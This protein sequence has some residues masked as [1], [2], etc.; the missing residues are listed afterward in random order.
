MEPLKDESA[1]ALGAELGLPSA[2][3]GFFL[4]GSLGRAMSD[5]AS[6]TS[7][8]ALAAASFSFLVLRGEAEGD[9]GGAVEALEATEEERARRGVDLR[10]GVDLRA[11][12]AAGMIASVAREIE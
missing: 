2:S 7:L 5:L 6:L 10:V 1:L 4:V 12:A 3:L 8:A 11:E 9:A